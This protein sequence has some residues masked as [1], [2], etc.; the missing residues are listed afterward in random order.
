METKLLYKVGQV[1]TAKVTRTGSKFALLEDKNNS[2]FIIYKNEVTD[3]Y[4]M[5]VYDILQV[6]DIVNFVVT[7]YDQNTNQYIG[8]FKRN[9]PNFL[10]SEQYF[11]NSKNRKNELKE[12]KN[13]FA[14]LREFTLSYIDPEAAKKA[15][16]DEATNI[17]E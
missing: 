2:K 14:N 17:K 3:F 7:G 12:T 13:G 4:K 11:S 9:H 1:V 5:Q 10:K 8:S 6:K 16:E 15:A